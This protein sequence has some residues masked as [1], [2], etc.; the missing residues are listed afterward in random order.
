MNVSAQDFASKAH[1]GQ[2]YGPYSYTKHLADVESVLRRFGFEDED[3]LTSAWLHDCVEDANVS[4]HDIAGRF[5]LNVAVL[6]Y[7]VT[8]GKGK[9]RRERKAASYRKMAERPRAII[10]KLADRIAN[11]ENSIVSNAG[12]LQMYRKEHPLFTQKLASA[13]P[14]EAAAMWDHLDALL[15]DESMK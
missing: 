14:A 4:I 5:G 2:M 13:S 11:I 15:V 6:V 10:L 1:A 8:D 12:L 3:L 9:N 7:A